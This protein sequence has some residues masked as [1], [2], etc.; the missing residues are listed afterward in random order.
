MLT[1]GLSFALVPT[2]VACS[3]GAGGRSRP[4]RDLAQMPDPAW[5]EPRN[6][7]ITPERTLTPRTHT[8]PPA[9]AP[10][11]INTALPSG[12]RPRST[13]AGGNPVPSLMDRMTPISRLTIHHDGMTPFT[14]TGTAAAQA[15]IEAIRAA[16]RG[17]GWGDIGYHY[18]LDPAGRLWEG[19]PLAWQGAH[20]GEQNRGN[21]GICVL[22]NYEQQRPTGA[23]LDALERFVAQSM[24]THNIALRD[25]YTHRELAPTAC[26]GRYLQPRLVAMRENTGVLARV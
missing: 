22:G 24:R 15:R 8:L 3:S 12:V 5:P 11:G 6:L 26:P 16:H 14:A 4:S 10:S 20:V 18:V 21:L 25:V 9:P 1:A 7:T 13:W 2:L 23:Q 17:R 19:R